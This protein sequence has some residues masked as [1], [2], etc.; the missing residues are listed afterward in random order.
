LKN[1]MFAIIAP[2]VSATVSNP[3]A[4]RQPISLT[5]PPVTDEV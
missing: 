2:A 3:A 5:T 4:T 1:W